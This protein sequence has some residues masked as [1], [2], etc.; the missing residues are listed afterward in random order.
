MT[1][2]EAEAAKLA[3]GEELKLPEKTQKSKDTEDE[4]MMSHS[5]RRQLRAAAPGQRRTPQA[6]AATGTLE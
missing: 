3:K 1:K 4:E 5:R 2:I 6:P